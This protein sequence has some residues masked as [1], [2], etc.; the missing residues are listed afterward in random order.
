MFDVDHFPKPFF[1]I[2]S[3]YGGHPNLLTTGY[4]RVLST[5]SDSEPAIALVW[6]VVS[7]HA[8][9]QQSTS[10]RFYDIPKNI[11]VIDIAYSDG[12]YDCE[13]NRVA[14]STFLDAIKKFANT[15]LVKEV[16]K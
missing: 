7:R 3:F 11:L 1:Q 4:K 2:S 16:D 12:F 14:K 5:V 15:G 10:R 8:L 9:P 6:H 13:M